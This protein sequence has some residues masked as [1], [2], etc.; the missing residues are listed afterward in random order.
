MQFGET[1]DRIQQPLVLSLSQLGDSGPIP[2]LEAE[3]IRFREGFALR[4]FPV[5]S[6]LSNSYNR[7]RGS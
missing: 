4:E 6:T 5:G 1:F 7:F 3:V 2:K